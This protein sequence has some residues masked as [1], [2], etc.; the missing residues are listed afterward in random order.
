MIAIRSWMA[1][2]VGA[3]LLMMVGTVAQAG[4]LYTDGPVGSSGGWNISALQVEDSF[5]V[6]NGTIDGV[7]VGTWVTHGDTAS[8]VEW[9]I[10]GSEGSQIPVCLACS[11]TASLFSSTLLA[12]DAYGTWDVYD[13][14]FSVPDL[15][16]TAG[17]YWLELQ[18]EVV[19]NFGTGLWDS[20]GGP[21]D[22]WVE[23]FGDQ[24]GANCVVSPAP[25]SDSF[26]ILGSAATASEPTS[27][28]LLGAALLGL[29]VSRRRRSAAAASERLLGDPDK[30]RHE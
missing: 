12:S 14:G 13:L 19:S 1:V 20:N 8:S 11:G 16:L 27:L 9:S 4:V 10:V 7:T 18:H 24:S 21:S 17:K 22:T 29:G 26:E 23:F 15:A 2:A 3:A 28:A 30:E 5:T 6:P 25:C